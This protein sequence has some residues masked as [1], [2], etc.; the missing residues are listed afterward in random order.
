MHA[1]SSTL[2]QWL[3]ERILSVLNRRAIH[4]PF[5]VWCDPRNIWKELLQ[6]AAE[7]ETFELW[8]DEVHELLLRDRF[9]SAPRAPRLVW[10][11]VSSDEITYFKVYAIQAVEVVELRLSDALAQFGVELSPDHWAELEPLLP[12]HARQWID[13]P[14]SHWREHLSPGQVKISLVPVTD[15]AGQAVGGYDDE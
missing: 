13:Y 9:Y 4:A 14:L 3:Q 15:E 11:P 2:R 7:G 5:I 12:A 10:L 6:L 8:A 1:S